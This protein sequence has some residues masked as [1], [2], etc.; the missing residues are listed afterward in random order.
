MD[1]LGPPLIDFEVKHGLHARELQEEHVVE[2]G[3]I[4]HF[5]QFL[6]VGFRRSISSWSP[7]EVLGNGSHDVEQN[8]MVP[9]FMNSPILYFKEMQWTDEV[10]DLSSFDRTD[11]VNTSWHRKVLRDGVEGSRCL[12]VPRVAA[13]LN[14]IVAWTI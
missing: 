7:F 11:E 2:N 13:G 5:E 9:G 3:V 4:D 10:L 8:F 14:K 6:Q 1:S 12:S